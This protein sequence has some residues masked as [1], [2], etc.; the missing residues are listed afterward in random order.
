MNDKFEWYDG[1]PPEDLVSNPSPM[2]VIFPG[3]NGPII[4]IIGATH[5]ELLCIDEA[6]KP[7]V[8]S[9][10]NEMNTA[11]S[12]PYES[13]AHAM[14]CYIE[15]LTAIYQHNDHDVS[16]AV[17]KSVEP[18]P[19]IHFFSKGS[20]STQE[21]EQAYFEKMLPRMLSRAASLIFAEVR[22]DIDIVSIVLSRSH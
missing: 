5:K 19:E 21:R 13:V 3:R 18:N 16:I 6:I 7:I 20:Q 22:P 14:N 10:T 2:A 9:V 8:C 12:A 11:R 1:R 15:T 17:L 4:E